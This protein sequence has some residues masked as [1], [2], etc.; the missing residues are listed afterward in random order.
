LL[1]K[2]RVSVLESQVQLLTSLRNSSHDLFHALVAALIQVLHVHIVL[3]FPLILLHELICP[4]G[5]QTGLMLARPALDWLPA[6]RRLNLAG[7]AHDLVGPTLRGLVV[8]LWEGNLE[9]FPHERRLLHHFV[10]VLQNHVVNMD[11]L[12]LEVKQIALL[13]RVIH[14]EHVVALAFSAPAI[15]QITV[16]SLLVCSSN[17]LSLFTV[18]EGR[19]VLLESASAHLASAK[20]LRKA[21]RN[22]VFKHLLPSA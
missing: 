5:L 17:F 6:A 2:T 19:K 8:K 22:S 16:L 10:N 11:E 9:N 13:V 1:L 3:V 12:R 18:A 4:E 15:V 21:H 14:L 20:L 7:L